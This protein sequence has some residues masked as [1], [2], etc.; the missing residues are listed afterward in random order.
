[1]SIFY[2]VGTVRTAEMSLDKSPL[3]GLT[4]K[5][6]AGTAQK[7]PLRDTPLQGSVR[8]IQTKVRGKKSESITI[9]VDS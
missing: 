6:R 2:V 8:R 9:L 7:V 1:M 4:P 5:L 3:E